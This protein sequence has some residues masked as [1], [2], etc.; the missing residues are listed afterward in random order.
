[1][2]GAGAGSS[3]ANPSFPVITSVFTDKLRAQL[4]ANCQTTFTNFS[5]GTAPT[6]DWARTGLVQKMQDSMNG[7]LF[8]AIMDGVEAM[9]SN[10]PARQQSEQMLTYMLDAASQND[11]LAAMLG[12]ANDVIQ[13]LRDDTNLIPLY[14]L[15]ATAA[16]PSVR[17]AQGNLTQRGM[18]DASLALL[19]RMSGKAMDASGNE[20][21]SLEL[22][23]NQVMSTALANLVTP[24]GGQNGQP[25]GETPL[26]V[27]LSVLA[28]V[29]RAAP[30][31]TDK[32]GGPDYASIAGNMVSFFLDKE[33]G[34]EQVYQVIRIG[35]TPQ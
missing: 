22:D 35:T 16:A 1:V 9:R 26:E 12:S 25:Q 8:A 17:D 6:C 15:L 13:A 21:C 18:V 4:Y 34:L 33:R 28:D 32:L 23:P 14:H 11:A 10:D 30:D 5:G 7:P 2:Y 31:H 3:F 27:M 24:M 19:S 20:I 29:N